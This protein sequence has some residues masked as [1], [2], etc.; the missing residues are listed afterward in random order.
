MC[1]Y[2]LSALFGFYFEELYISVQQVYENVVG[3]RLLSMV[4]GTGVS[5]FGVVHLLYNALRDLP[6]RCNLCTHSLR[7][8]FRYYFGELYRFVQQVYDN[9]VGF[10]L[11]SMVC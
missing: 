3:F 9:V 11:L 1:T 5:G 2:R 7:A 8:L 4:W 6:S 10:R